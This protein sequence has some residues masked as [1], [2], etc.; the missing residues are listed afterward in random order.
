[1]LR[2]F[3]KKDLQLQEEDI[4]KCEVQT[5]NYCKAES[6][7][8]SCPAPSILTSFIFPTCPHQV[9]HTYVLYLNEEFD[10]SMLK[11]LVEH[12]GILKNVLLTVY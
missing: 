12:S 2:I 7:P 6:I 10:F 8:Q 1:M 11:W 3:H 4:L 5:C 9:L